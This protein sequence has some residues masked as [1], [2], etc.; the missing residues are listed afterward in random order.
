MTCSLVSSD[1]CL[2][3]P[4]LSSP[5]LMFVLHSLVHLWRFLPLR[6]LRDAHWLS[7]VGVSSTLLLELGSVLGFSVRRC[8]SISCGSWEG[9]F[10]EGASCLDMSS[11]HHCWVTWFAMVVVSLV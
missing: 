8:F 10:V 7:H 4:S 9:W 6:Y 11:Q 3:F 5:L 2:V 1:G